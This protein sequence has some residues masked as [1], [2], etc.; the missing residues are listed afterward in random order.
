[1]S[2]NDVK[3]MGD[4]TLSGGAYGRVKIMGDSIV[5]GELEAEDLAVMGNISA[6]EKVKTGKLKITGDGRFGTIAA[7]EIS[8]SGS[9]EFRNAATV[10]VLDIMGEVKAYNGI[11]A[12]RIK[13]R[14]SI[15]DKKAIETECFECYGGMD[16]NTLNAE[17]I[18]I[19]LYGQNA[20]KEMVGSSINVIYP[21][22][23]K[24]LLG[25]FFF[26]R[27]W[28][29][30]EADTIE[31][32]RIYLERTTAASV[33]GKEVNIGPGCKIKYLEYKDK[34]TIDKSST[35]EKQVKV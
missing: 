16:V 23:R 27:N 21:I 14:G 3:L 19:K 12:K 17:N 32:D 29:S 20:A 33:K 5:S 28:A 31:A 15:E 9:I 11:K 30:M 10:G 1:M 18:S 34:I 4:G 35:V 7:D 8:V 2:K 6:D 26:K 24:V 25:L 13:V 22:Y